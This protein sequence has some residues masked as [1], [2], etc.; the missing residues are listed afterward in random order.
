MPHALEQRENINN[1]G[2]E[3]INANK[4]IAYTQA[5][6]RCVAQGK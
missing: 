4:Q 5:V 1:G 3:L 6:S 2:K